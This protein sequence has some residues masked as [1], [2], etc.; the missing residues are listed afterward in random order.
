MYVFYEVIVNLVL[1]CV[2]R[3][4]ACVVAPLACC[5][6]AA[7]AEITPPWPGLS[8]LSSYCWESGLPASCWCLAW[9]AS[10][11]R[12]LTQ[13]IIRLTLTKNTCWEKT[14]TLS[15]NYQNK[16]KNGKFAFKILLTPLLFNVMHPLPGVKNVFMPLPPQLCISYNL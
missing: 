7:P 6:G 3:S 14:P 4:R 1:F 5:A 11:R 16:Y 10:S 8:M 13:I 9:R 15:Y 2:S 12:F